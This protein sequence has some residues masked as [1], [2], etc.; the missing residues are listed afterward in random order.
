[1]SVI[2][3]TKFPGDLAVFQKALAE[4]SEEFVRVRD[5]AVGL[6]ALHHC[7]AVGPDY[8]LV[9]DEWERE[10]QFGP[11]FGRPE[12]QQWIASVG[13]DFSVPPETWVGEAIDS[14]DKF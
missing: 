1:M 5:E 7:F 14:P 10:D 11:F 12:M 4:R 8:V 2:V 13:A 9:I 3:I 6:G